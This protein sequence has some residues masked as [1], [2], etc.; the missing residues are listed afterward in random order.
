[1]YWNMLSSLDSYMETLQFINAT[2]VPCPQLP[3]PSLSS[4]SLSDTLTTLPP[5]LGQLWEDSTVRAAIAVGDQDVHVATS[6]FAPTI[7]PTSHH[8]QSRVYL[9]SQLSHLQQEQGGRCVQ[10]VSE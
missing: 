9:L 3:L 7:R 6:E 10:L 8:L 1:M 2:A 5:L 4:L